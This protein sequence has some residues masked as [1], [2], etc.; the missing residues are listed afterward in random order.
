MNDWNAVFVLNGR[1]WTHARDE[2]DMAAPVVTV[3]AR[4]TYAAT[5]L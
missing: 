2:R 5:Q 1:F 3:V 4:G